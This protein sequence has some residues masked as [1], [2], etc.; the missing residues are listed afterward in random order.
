MDNH[1]CKNPQQNTSKQHIER[2]MHHD[3]VGYIPE[4]QGW[5]NMGQSIS[6]IYHINRIK[7]KKSHD[8]FNRCIKRI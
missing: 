6:I 2:I 7:G 5:F 3:S 8:H 1:G 4:M